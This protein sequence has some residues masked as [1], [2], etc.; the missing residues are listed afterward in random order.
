MKPDMT[1]TERVE[2][3]CFWSN[4]CSDSVRCQAF[5]SCLANYQRAEIVKS[6]APHTHQVMHRNPHGGSP[7]NWVPLEDYRS[8]ERQ[9]QAAR[10]FVAESALTTARAEALEE[11]AK[12]CEQ[13]AERMAEDSNNG[14]VESDTNAFI[15]TN[16][17]AEWVSI[18]VGE[19]AAR[20]IRA[21]TILQPEEGR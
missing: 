11:A 21:L 6:G 8:L 14:Y 20:A 10:A 5:G 12:V 19:D 9:L 4:G 2:E 17:E 15:W 13:M 18:I 3:K 16:K 7:S 1:N